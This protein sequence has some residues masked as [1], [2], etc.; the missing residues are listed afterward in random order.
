MTV[1]EITE[2]VSSFIGKLLVAGGGGGI[3]AYGVFRWLGRSWLDQRFK[4][5]LEQ[6]KHAQQKEIELLRYRVNSLFSRISK[7]H[8]KEF[9][10]LPIA[11][12]LLHRAHG[13]VFSAA[14][15][16]R[17]FVD[18]NAMS[19]PAFQEFL[20]GCPLA[21]HQ[22]NE[23]LMAKDKTK[24]YELAI[25]WIDLGVAQKAQTELSNYLALNSIFMTE[26]LRKQFKAFNET[27]ISI[28]SE[29]EIALQDSFVQRSPKAEKFQ[30]L[31]KLF[32]EIETVVQKR[33]RYE[34]A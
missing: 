4:Q 2:A 9:E 6:L 28:L 27:I 1:H 16:L 34:D 7:V 17:Q 33:L 11:W 24:Y 3:V 25:S 5:Q 22:K 13:S 32:D 12:G 21:E 10:I 29:E 20:S 8:E 14:A 15:H 19:E 26:E 30:R 18:V 31:S 23:L